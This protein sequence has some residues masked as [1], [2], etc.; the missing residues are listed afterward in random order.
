M[1]QVEDEA[2]KRFTA[3]VDLERL[4]QQM[5]ELAP[6]DADAIN[7]YIK[8]AKTFETLDMLDTSLRQRRVYQTLP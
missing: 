7:G 5:L 4:R 3:Y 2:G 6:Q 1:C 8:N